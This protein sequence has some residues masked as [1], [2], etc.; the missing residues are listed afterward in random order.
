[1][2]IIN[3]R[4]YEV[5]KIISEQLRS[6]SWA[7]AG[8]FTYF[9]W[10]NYRQVYGVVVFTLWFILQTFSLILISSGQKLIK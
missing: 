4:D 1:M 3:F 10:T 8:V 9:G 2:R 6:A 7:L 5:I